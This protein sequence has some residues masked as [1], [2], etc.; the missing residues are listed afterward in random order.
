MISF[1]ILL[2]TKNQWDCLILN[3]IIQKKYIL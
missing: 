2:C 3:A 1:Y